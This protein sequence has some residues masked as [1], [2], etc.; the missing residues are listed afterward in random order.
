MPP[1]GA[2]TPDGNPKSL[3]HFYSPPWADVSVTR[4]ARPF[5]RIPHPGHANIY[6]GGGRVRRER[7]KI[8]K[9]QV[10]WKFSESGRR[11]SFKVISLV[12]VQLLH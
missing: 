9:E 8:S 3:R 10:V 4:L 11:T 1:G 2:R 7:I 12:R 6:L 5:W